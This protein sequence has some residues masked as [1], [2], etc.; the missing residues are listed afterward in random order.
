MK[1]LSLRNLVFLAL[2][3][4]LGLAAKRLI[5]PLANIVTN[6]LHIPGG[7]GTSFSLM[8]LVIAAALVP[9]FGCATLAGAAQSG[10]A[11]CLGMVGSMGAL[12]PIGYILPGLAVD[13]TMAAGRKTGVPQKEQMVIANLLAGVCASFTAN[14]IIFRLRGAALALYLCVAAVSGG[15]CGLSGAQITKRLTPVFRTEQKTMRGM[16]CVR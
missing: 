12:S 10:T 15:I 9:H 8:F 3:C 14:C 1:R 2:C 16:E 4:D 11:L 13:L 6:S 7:I 5:N